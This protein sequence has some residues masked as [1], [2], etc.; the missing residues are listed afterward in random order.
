MV[1]A[2]GVLI[3]EHWRG[4]LVKLVCAVGWL[5]GFVGRGYGGGS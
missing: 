4:T 3:T 5:M 1:K 2:V